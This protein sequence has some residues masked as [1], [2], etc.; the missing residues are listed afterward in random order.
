M[1]I[2]TYE[3]NEYNQ[4]GAYFLG[5]FKTK[6]DIDEL[7]ELVHQLE[8]GHTNEYKLCEH[9]LTGGGR[10]CHEYRWYQL[11]EYVK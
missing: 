10:Q 8:N 1:W 4:D 11:F 9:I 6:P 5:A 7:Y 3:I 2:L